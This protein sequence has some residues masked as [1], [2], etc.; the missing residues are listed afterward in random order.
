MLLSQRCR[1]A[2][3]IITLAKKTEGNGLFFSELA[4]IST[5]FA[6]VYG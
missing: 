6:A 3:I 2:E 4:H 5:L 1:K